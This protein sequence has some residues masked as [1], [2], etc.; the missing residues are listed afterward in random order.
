MGC[1]FLPFCATAASYKQAIWMVYLVPVCCAA[2]LS[3]PMMFEAY[4]AHYVSIYAIGWWL[5]HRSRHQ[6]RLCCRCWVTAL[7]IQ[8]CGQPVQPW[9]PRLHSTSAQHAWR[10]RLH[11]Y[12][13]A[14][15]LDVACGST[16]LYRLQCKGSRHLAH[17]VLDGSTYLYLRTHVCVIPHLARPA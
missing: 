4:Q 16:S 10:L 17:I 12:L 13:P 1:T 6:L 2:S 3:L 5:L 15:A 14:A 11:L 9:P 8:S 7:S